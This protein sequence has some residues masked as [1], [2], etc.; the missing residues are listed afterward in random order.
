V[1][2]IR[3]RLLEHAPG[4]VALTTLPLQRACWVQSDGDTIRRVGWVC[5]A[6]ILARRMA[7]ATSGA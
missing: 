6:A 2:T 4:R 7:A 5:G 3:E 1:R